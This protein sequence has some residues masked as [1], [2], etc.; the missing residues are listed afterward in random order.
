M[1][2][3]IV[4]TLSAPQLFNGVRLMPNQSGPLLRAADESPSLRISPDGIRI[5]FRAPGIAPIDSIS[6]ARPV[7]AVADRISVPRLMCTILMK[8]T[9]V[10][11]PKAA[12]RLRP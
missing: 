8:A 9:A 4:V 2:H 7:T 5:A 6:D 10:A 12:V 11:V 1:G 3:R